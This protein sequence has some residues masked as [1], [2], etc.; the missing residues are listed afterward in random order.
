MCVTQV[1]TQISPWSIKT[2]QV[3]TE[4]QKR[5]L[6]NWISKSSFRKLASPPVYPANSCKTTA[7]HR[8]NVLSVQNGLNRKSLL[9]ATPGQ[10]MST[11]T[12][13]WSSARP[14]SWEGLPSSWCRW[15]WSAAIAKERIHVDEKYCLKCLSGSNPNLRFW[16]H[17]CKIYTKTH[18]FSVQI[19]K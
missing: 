16:Q 10:V 1:H 7:M 15:P 5:R 3:L 4:S 6:L 12:P 14:P 17:Q 2:I 18:I 11:H 8:L 13:G 9:A 19:S